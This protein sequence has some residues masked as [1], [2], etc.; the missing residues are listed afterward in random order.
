MYNKL[1]SFVDS[2]LKVR[3]SIAKLTGTDADDWFLCL[4]A[5][6]GLEMVFAAIKD[7]LGSGEV[8]TTPYTCITAINPILSGGLEPR[9]IDI[10]PELLSTSDIPKSKI[11]K[12][13]RAI[14]MQHTLGLIDNKNNLYNIAKKHNL[15]LVEDSAHCLLRMARG[16]ADLPLADVSV[17]SFGVEKVLPGT[18]FGGAIYVN[19]H[20]KAKHPQLYEAICNRLIKLKQPPAGLSFRLR[21]YRISNAAIQRLP[22]S[23]K[24]TVR[25]L[26]VKT[27]ILEPAVYDFEQEG[28]QATPYNTNQFVNETILRELPGLKANYDRRLSNTKYYREHLDSK[29]FTPIAQGPQD[30][31]LLAYPIVF[32]DATF[33]DYAYDLLT[34]SG[35]FIRRWYKPLLYPGPRFNQ[36]YS[37]D[38]EKYPIA[39]SFSRRVLC[40]PTD[41]PLS[42]TKRVIELIAPVEKTV[43]NNSS[44]VEK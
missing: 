17:H 5:R 16:T 32:E 39:E 31:P 15:V 11:T 4:K 42:Q 13:T 26:A 2:S 34:N 27:K 24:T 33:A 28:R 19:P 43:E 23:L 25:H 30:E 1:M 14:V 12:R 3:R 40:L 7:T 9:Y 21:N 44:P 18:K 35:F 22:K 20:L 41:L 37:Y 6:F 10:D 29:K 8:F 38:P 36:I